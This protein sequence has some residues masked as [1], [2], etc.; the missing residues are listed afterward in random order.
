MCFSN[1][2]NRFG[3]MQVFLNFGVYYDGS[4]HQQ[5]QKEEK[6]K[7]QK[8]LNNTLS[9][10]EVMLYLGFDCMYD[11]ICYDNFCPFTWK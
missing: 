8:D 4:D 10:I 11:P 3:S 9:T 7:V 1:F 2:H 6:K 5:K